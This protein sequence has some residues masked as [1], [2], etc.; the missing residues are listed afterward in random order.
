M[1]PLGFLGF[2]VFAL[3][4]WA[5]Y[6]ALVALGV[7]VAPESGW[8]R[9][10][11]GGSA[12]TGGPRAP[13]RS[14]IRHTIVAG[15]LTALF[16]VIVLLGMERRT[17]SSVAPRLDATSVETAALA[18]LKGIGITHAA[19]LGDLGIAGVCAL[20]RR[21]PEELFRQIEN[22]VPRGAGRRL[23]PT[24]AEVRVWVGAARREC[25]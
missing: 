2:P 1:P 22:T 13:S 19:T 25:D 6:H 18:R 16:S 7:G 24:Y 9:S 11:A 15:G 17:I 3:E 8:T 5:M 4:A 20:S 14:A 12:S 23:R 21:D 10:D